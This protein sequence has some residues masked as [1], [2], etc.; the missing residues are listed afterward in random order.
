MNED[1]ESAKAMLAELQKGLHRREK[2]MTEHIDTS[3]F[4]SHFQGVVLT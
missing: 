2:G 4:E 3:L 1:E